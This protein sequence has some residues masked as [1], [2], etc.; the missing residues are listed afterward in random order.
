MQGWV[1]IHKQLTCTTC[2]LEYTLL[3]LKPFRKEWTIYS[4]CVWG[5]KFIDGIHGKKH[6]CI[7]IHPVPESES[8]FYHTKAFNPTTAASESDKKWRWELLKSLSTVSEVPG[9]V[10]VGVF[11]VHFP[12]KIAVGVLC[13]S[14][15]HT[16][17]PT[18]GLLYGL[19]NT[20]NHWQGKMDDMYPAHC[21]QITPF[22]GYERHLWHILEPWVFTEGI[23]SWTCCI[24]FTPIFSPNSITIRAQLTQ[25]QINDFKPSQKNSAE[26]TTAV[27]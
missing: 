11:C 23:G 21:A 8:P 24:K 18:L 25:L 1:L 4:K 26:Y 12:E 13:D 16:V 14:Q 3:E 22:H 27:W 9:K 5:L 17:Y 7:S 6:V 10:C 15:R 2:I 20:W 19:C